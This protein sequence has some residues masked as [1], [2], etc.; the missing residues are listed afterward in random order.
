MGPL[1]GPASADILFVI[2]KVNGFEI[3]LMIPNLF[4]ID[5]V[6]MTYLHCLLLL[7]MQ[8][9]LHI[10]HLNVPTCILL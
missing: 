9:N 7:I 10:Y 2:L 5:V 8:I 4:S 3:V 1:L 6:L